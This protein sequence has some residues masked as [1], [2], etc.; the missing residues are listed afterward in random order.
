MH[1]A[2]N[3]RRGM[4][5]AEARR[6]ALISSGGIELARGGV[7]ERKGIPWLEATIS[8]ARY[9]YRSLRNR[10][11]F[12]VVAVATLALGIGATTAM[13]SVVEGVLLEPLP[14]PQSD[15]LVA[16]NTVSEGEIG[17]VSPAD[18][19]DWRARASSLS[20]VD[21]AETIRVE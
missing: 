18:L 6:E 11:A 14:Y 21:P 4:T 5:P 16:L 1:V 13:F 19:M 20:V 15:R 7:R 10:P 17:P 3:I 8:D 2:E 9:A 12:A